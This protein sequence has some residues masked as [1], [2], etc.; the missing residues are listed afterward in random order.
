MLFSGCD[1]TMASLS[2]SA[3]VTPTGPIKA[4]TSQNVY[5]FRTCDLWA[6]LPTEEQLVT[7][8][9]LGR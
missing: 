2:S 7:K 9:F 3:V 8:S 6:L 1:M 5:I 4:H